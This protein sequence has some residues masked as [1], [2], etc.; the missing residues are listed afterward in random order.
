MVA[1]ELKPEFGFVLLVLLFGALTVNGWMSVQVGGARKKYNVKY[2]TMYA[3][4]ATNKDAKLFNCYQRAHQNTLE[5]YPTFLTLLLPS[6]LRFPITAAVAGF[7][8]L[9]GRIAYFKGYATG[10]PSKRMNGSF[11]YLGLFTLMG[12][13]GRFAFELLSPIVLGKLA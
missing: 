10:D 8:Y 11:Q 4:E 6:G 2:P 1:L 9:L 5:N 7:V 3:D 12:C 13:V